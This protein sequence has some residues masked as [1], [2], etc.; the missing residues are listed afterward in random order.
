M[1]HHATHPAPPAHAAA[2]PREPDPAR[3][4]ITLTV[5]DQPVDCIRPADTTAPT[6]ALYRTAPQ[7]A[8]AYLGTVHAHP[9][10]PA[11]WRVQATGERH[12]TFADAVRTLRRPGSWPRDRAHA[13]SWAR[14]AL[15]D[16]ATLIVDVQTTGLHEPYAVQIAAIDTSGTLRLDHTLDPQAAIDPAASALHG[17]TASSTAQAATFSDIVAELTHLTHNRRLVA[18]NSTFDRHV[19]QRDLQR[20]Y[21]QHHKVNAW[22]Q[23]RSWHNALPPIAAA[24]GLWSERRQAYRYPRLGGNYD[25]AA[26]CTLLLERLRHLAS[27][28]T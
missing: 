4:V 27:A 26:H 18:Y 22:L 10:T 2:H 5:D 9:G 25:A 21:Q 24:S 17:L 28:G 15:A 1:H 7:A 11:A 3:D 23:Q 13:I 20:H 14:K 16:P 19:I 6:W 12:P 8:P